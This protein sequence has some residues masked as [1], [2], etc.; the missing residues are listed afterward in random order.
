[1]FWTGSRRRFLAT[2]SVVGLS[3]KQISCQSPG[4]SMQSPE[5]ARPKPIQP[6][7]T[8]GLICPGSPVLPA[9]VES[10]VNYLEGRGYAVKRGRHLTEPYLCDMS[11]TDAQ[12]AA[13]LNG[14]IADEAVDAVFTLRGGYGTHRLLGAVN[15]AAL[16]R[17][18]KWITGFSDVT[19]LH[20]ALFQRLG[21]LSL[22]GPAFAY[23]FGDEAVPKHV[24]RAWWNTVEGIDLQGEWACFTDPAWQREQPI[25][26]WVGGQ[27]RGRLYGGNL[28]RL[29][30]LAGTPYAIPEGQPLILFLE[31]VG[32][33][34]YRIDRFLTQLRESGALASV[35]GVLV[36]DHT[37]DDDDA[38]E[39][40]HIR[41]SLKDRLTD[42]GVPVLAGLPIGHTQDNLPVA[43]G[44]WV[45]MDTQVPSVR[46]AHSKG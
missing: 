9:E 46:Y 38:D 16:A 1:M 40:P 23:T 5:F 14:M 29:A 11:G 35:Q 22:H 15:Y 44:A 17:H 12:R 36:G 6:G 41:A 18:P 30:S 4:I 3:L 39:R 32:E 10:A 19:S 20:N 25:E 34:A 28:S 42:L 27:A 31:E 21:L 45:E 24:E 26:V 13:D 37:V 43:H 7:A 2:L 33:A 8:I